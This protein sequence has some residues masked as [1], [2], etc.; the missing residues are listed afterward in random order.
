MYGIVQHQKMSSV[1]QNN[2]EMVNYTRISEVRC[3]SL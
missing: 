2:I 3:N 1:E